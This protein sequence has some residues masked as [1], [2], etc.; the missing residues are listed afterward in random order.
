[1]QKVKKVLPFIAAGL[2]LLAIIFLALP[3][4][5]DGDESAKGFALIFG[6]DMIE[7][8]GGFEEKFAYF[9]FSFVNF[10]A[11]L[12]VIGGAVLVLIGVKNENKA[13]KI[14][15]AILFIV[16][17]V[18]F[19]CM[20]RNFAFDK[21]AEIFEDYVAEDFKFEKE[22]LIEYMGLGAGA[23][24]PAICSILAG[25]AALLPVFLPDEK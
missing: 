12:F 3:A 19:F 8:D 6:G 22:W 17:A 7:G 23:I 10:L 21:S 16:A 2:A 5:N 13:L 15:A 24:L 14:V 25:V 4:I 11:F 9:G 18:L 20:L 1:M